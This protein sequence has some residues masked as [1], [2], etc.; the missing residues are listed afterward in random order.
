MIANESAPAATTSLRR[1]FFDVLEGG[2]DSPRAKLVNGF[3][4]TLI[5]INVFAVVLESEPG[6]YVDYKTVFYAIEIFSVSIFTLEYLARI[7]CRP[8]NSAV[9]G[10]SSL[11]QRLKFVFSPIGLIDLL[12]IAPFYLAMLFAIDLRYLRLL[13]LMRLLKISH[14]FHG[15]DLFVDVLRTEAKTITSAILTVLML[16][17]VV[18]ALMFTFEHNAQPEAFGSI[19]QSIWWSVVTLT[20][21]GYGD[22]TP[23]TF[24][25]KILAMFIMLLGVGLVALPAGI[26]AAKF[27]EELKSR[28]DQL[29]NRLNVA[30]AD[31]IVDADE[32]AELSALREELRLSERVLEQMLQ[33]RTGSTA[34]FS[35]PECGH[36]L[37]LNLRAPDSP[38]AK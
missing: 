2:F 4:V 19:L 25:G 21:V 14:Y 35:C 1:R 18:A 29:S 34:Q 11:K 28:R 17:I 36:T 7:W 8:E 38:D 10:E 33:N 30:L 6:L 15:L 12:A 22:V 26:L 9:S 5:L 20:T 27:S 37:A 16:I 13:R 31:G 24:G 3:I 32:H 23:V